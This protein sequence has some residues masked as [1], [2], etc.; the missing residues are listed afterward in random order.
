MLQAFIEIPSD[1]ET[2]T[3]QVESDA[4]PSVERVDVERVDVDDADRDSQSEADI[5]EDEELSEY[6]EI[7]DDGGNFYIGR[8]KQTRWRKTQIAPRAKTRGKNIVKKLPGPTSHARDA[9]TELEAYLKIM[10][11]DI[12][13]EIVKCTNKYM[14]GIRHKFARE[15]RC[16]ETS[17]SEIIALLLLLLLLHYTGCH[18]RKGPNFGRVFLMLNYTDI[19]QN[20]YIQS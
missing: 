15:R 9:S 17:R 5:S 20:T 12:V 6:D 11:I 4:D 2:T 13:D 18:R 14:Q 16:T 1:E 3:D 19:T 7:D 10:D 8:D